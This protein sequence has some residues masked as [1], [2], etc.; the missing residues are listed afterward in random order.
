MAESGLA[1]LID[2][3]DQLLHQRRSIGNGPAGKLK[4][5]EIAIKLD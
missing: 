5:A 2:Q 4:L 3:I 1:Q